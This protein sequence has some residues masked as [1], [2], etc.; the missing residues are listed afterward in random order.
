[1]NIYANVCFLYENAR[2]SWFDLPDGAIPAIDLVKIW[3]MAWTTVL[4]LCLWE[5]LVCRGLVTF[6]VRK[7]TTI[8][9]E[10]LEE[11]QE[12]D[13]AISQRQSVFKK[14]ISHTKVQKTV[15][16]DFKG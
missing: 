5:H 14:F 13:S 15:I 16:G 7:M 10:N 9:K 11:D 12:D 3:G 2:M 4:V 6:L 1:M 8:S